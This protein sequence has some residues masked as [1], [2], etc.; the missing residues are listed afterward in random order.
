MKQFSIIL[1]A[2]IV[3][4]VACDK[5]IVQPENDS[6]GIPA[7]TFNLTAQHPEE[8]ATKAI[9]T[10]WEDG[11]VVFVFFSGV[12]APKYLRMSYNQGTWTSA[13][14]DGDTPG[15]LGL[16]NGNSGTMRAVYLPF[17]N[18]L[19]VTVS[20][21]RFVFSEIQYT[22]Y[23]TA[24]L[25]YTVTDNT[26]S[27]AFDMQ[28]PNNYVQ[29]YITD[30][31]A[32]DEAYTLG[33][34]AVIPT[35]IAYINTNGS[36][37]ETSDKTYAD[38]LPGYAY[39]GGYLFSGKLLTSYSYSYNYYFAKTKVGG[40]N[41]SREDYFVGEFSKRLKSHS[42]VKLPANGSDSWQKVG[43]NES[44]TLKKKNGDDMGKWF[45][46]N[47]GESVPEG[48][49]ENYRYDF[50]QA[51]AITGTPTHDQLNSLINDT[52]TRAAVSIH[53]QWGYVFQAYSG[54]FLFIPGQ[55]GSSGGVLSC[56]EYNYNNNSY[57]WDMEFN[58]NNSPSMATN[59]KYFTW[60][61]RLLDTRVQ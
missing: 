24:T 22:Y 36:I 13:E 58:T 15:S 31:E 38:D 34:D 9:K 6:E 42:A 56:T 14:M 7:I 53:G 32:V 46:C 27:G 10:G 41:N 61:L 2:T 17:G 47:Y 21:S 4:L 59:P 48:A 35:G 18:N 54:G 60:P 51:Q 12:P 23:L 55:Y 37:T 52:K 57:A 45:T 44:V 8:A 49:D 28:I 20:N 39:K 5:E 26:V 40:N 19:S 3:T 1:L 29:L 30:E 43:P 11:D 33:C 25:A 50:S 16:S